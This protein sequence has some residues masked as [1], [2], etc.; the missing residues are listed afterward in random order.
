MQGGGSC[1]P[2]QYAVMMDDSKSASCHASQAE[3][4]AEMKRMAMAKTV[5]FTGTVTVA[6]TTD[7]KRQTF[8]WASIAVKSDGSQLVDTDGDIIEPEDLEDMAYRHVLEFRAAGVDHDGEPPVGQLIESMVFTPEK[9]KALGIP[10]GVLP[11]AGW[12]I[13]VEWPDTDQGRAI[14]SAAKSGEKAWWSIEGT[15]ETEDIP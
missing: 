11:K 4:M 5:D 9:A 7:E 8:G 1:G 6:K 14:Y 2:S 15:F 13:G 3:A 10:D 12:W